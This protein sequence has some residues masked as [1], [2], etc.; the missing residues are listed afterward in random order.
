MT[1]ALGHGRQHG[2]LRPDYGPQWAELAC[3]TCHA[4]W[5]GIINDPCTWC[6]QALQRLLADQRHNLLHPP[7]LHDNDGPRHDELMWAARLRRAVEADLITDL[8]ARNA[9]RRVG[10]AT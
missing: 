1:A 3:D 7:W 10:H 5:V 8:E 2:P 4:T 6:E 9:I